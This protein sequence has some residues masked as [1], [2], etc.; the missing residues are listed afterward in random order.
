MSLVY[1]IFRGNSSGGPVDYSSPIATVSTLSYTDAALPLSSTTRYGVR[2]RDTV[3]GLADLNTD[4]TVLI[5]VGATGADI[6]A[7]PP[8]PAALRALAQPG[9]AV[10]VEW[11]HPALSGPRPTGF[12]VYQGVGS[13]SYGSPV[14]AVPYTGPGTHYRALISGLTSGTTYLFGVRAYNATAEEANTIT[15]AA[16]ASSAGP[17]NPINLTATPTSQG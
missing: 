14:A 12:H 4:A 2:A 7:Q 10:L 3:S 9:G 1:D 17:T 5:R 13:V 6:T 16:T 15:A 11:A 8:A